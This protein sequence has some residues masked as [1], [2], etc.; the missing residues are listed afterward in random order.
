MWGATFT[1]HVGTRAKRGA[2]G[3]FLSDA[4]FRS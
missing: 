1:D 4:Y 3:R 2:N